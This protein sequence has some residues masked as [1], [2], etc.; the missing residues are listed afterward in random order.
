MNKKESYIKESVRNCMKEIEREKIYNDAK[1]ITKMF[2]PND[3]KFMTGTVW[4]DKE[5][6]AMRTTLDDYLDRGELVYLDRH[7][8]RLESQVAEYRASRDYY[9]TLAQ[10]QFDTLTILKKLQA[11]YGRDNN[12]SD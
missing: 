11:Q 5:R 4:T 8:T 1:L 3:E 7:I 10:E 2:I 12:T 9:A 6:Q